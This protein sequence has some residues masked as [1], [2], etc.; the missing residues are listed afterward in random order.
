MPILDSGGGMDAWPREVFTLRCN[1]IRPFSVTDKLKRKK[2]S[3]NFHT[4]SIIP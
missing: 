2:K 4:K 3:Y 1:V